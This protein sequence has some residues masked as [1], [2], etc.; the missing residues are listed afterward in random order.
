M[1]LNATSFKGDGIEYWNTNKIENMRCMFY[2]ATLF[3]ANL[4]MWNTS[5]VLDSS[6]MFYNTSFRGIG[7]DQWNTKNIVTMA[8]MF[9]YA[10]LFDANLSSWDVSQYNC[11]LFARITLRRRARMPN[12]KRIAPLLYFYIFDLFFRY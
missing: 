11:F 2:G 12:T 5:Q 3:D 6:W 4:S 1:L 8:R 7:I 10:S 9:S